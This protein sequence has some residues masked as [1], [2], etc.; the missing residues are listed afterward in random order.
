MK[1]YF[2]E[3]LLFFVC[4]VILIA[5]QP[6]QDAF[7][8]NE[9]GELIIS[10]DNGQYFF[11][12]EFIVLYNEENPVPA[13]RPGDVENVLYNIITWQGVKTEEQLRKPE[14]RDD[15]EFGDGF[16]DRILD[17]GVSE[18]TFNLFNA[19]HIQAYSF[20]KVVKSGNLYTLHFREEDLGQ[21][22]VSIETSGMKPI[23]HLEFTPARDGYFSIGYVGAPKSAIE[24]AD[25]IWQPMIWQEK[26]LPESSFMTMAFRC[27]LPTTMLSLK[28]TSIGV[29]AHPEEF[30]FDPLPTMENS[31]FGVAVRNLSGEAQPL[32]FAPVLGGQESYRKN[33]ETYTF[34]MMPWAIAGDLRDAYEQL[35]TE[36]YGFRDYR[37]NDI[38]SLNETFENIVNYGMSEYA[39][40]LDSLKGCAYST[41]VPGAVKNVSS[42]HPLQLAMVM[43]DQDMYDQRAYPI[44]EYML[45]REKFLFSL[46]PE[47]RIQYP[48]R[49]LHGPIAP[50]T[51][52]A[53]LHRIT[54]EANPYLIDMAK[55]EFQTSRIRNLD[56]VEQGDHWRNA[57]AIYHAS[58]DE[59]FKALAK[60]GLADY[61]EN[62]VD[63]PAMDFSDPESGGFFFWTGFTPRW[64]DLFESYERLGDEEYLKAAHQGARSYTM[65]CW[66]SPGIPDDSILVNKG[67]KAPW[68]WYLKSKGHS[69]MF[70]PEEWAPAWRL[71]EIGLTPESSGTCQGHR[72]IFMANYA[73][74]MLRIGYL[75]GDEFLKNVAK[76]AII[77][78]YRNFPGYHI[79]TA[80][81]TAYEK[82]DYPLRPHKELSV[83]SF[84]Y[85]HILPMA[86][87]LLDYLIT[88]AE[89]RSEGAIQ[90]PSEYIEAYAYLQ[91]KYYGHKKGVFYG[92][93]VWL[94]MP[95]QLLQLSSKE[96]NYIS[97]R[98]DDQLMIS[99]M[100]QSPEDI[101][102]NLS[103]NEKIVPEVSGKSFQV[104]LI[105]NKHK[106]QPGQLQNGSIELL[107]PA[108][109]TVSFK[110]KDLKVKA[111][112]QESI[113]ARADVWSNAYAELK[114]GNTRAMILNIGK[115]TTNAYVYLRDND[116]QW[117]EVTLRY[118]N[119]RGETLEAFDNNFPFEFTVPLDQNADLF[120]FQILL[121][122]LQGKST[123]SEWYKLN[124]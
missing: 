83:N 14:G 8:V 77:G 10:N 48:S 101:K 54:R 76:A 30:P 73:P 1:V 59:K 52:L 116:Q 42:L 64:I 25:E 17:A 108:H 9:R 27:P 93:S 26:R 120:E 74:W 45:S 84:H 5:C 29:L 22:K 112:F 58:G 103:I 90:F 41:D 6:K 39:W 65:F 7:E 110:I 43:D 118:K 13:M 75:T 15:Q 107:V 78:R 91:N 34:K 71:S 80:R 46:D 106:I 105:G 95:Q 111:D 87:M 99:L 81:T 21:L 35:S 20:D 124:K 69:Q 23:M 51:E 49:N 68:Y 113:L 121:K 37:K 72:A 123:I 18:R 62:R 32:L 60:Q 102:L 122:D 86:V 82:Y 24:E 114:P 70:F 98:S 100:N 2:F 4:L 85:N 57:L 66:M 55:S 96:I 79:N 50:I 44:L 11:K 36:V 104:E 63:A 67:G 3:K 109:G 88:D 40:F 16:D 56:V 53:A 117:K 97:A 47:Q 28:G 119:A 31:R 92:D 115:L 94:W 33:G 12:P 19:G 89:V 38:A 61:Y